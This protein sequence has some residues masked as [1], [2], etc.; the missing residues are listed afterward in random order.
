MPY[1]MLT[2]GE[3]VSATR[4][5]TGISTSYLMPYGMLTVGERVRATRVAH[6]AVGEKVWAAR[7]ATDISTGY[8]MPCGMLT[9]G[10]RVE[11]TRSAASHSIGSLLGAGYRHAA[12]QHGGSS[13]AV[14]KDEV[15][16]HAFDG[17][18]HF[19]EVACDGDL[20]DRI[21]QLSVV[22][23][24]ADGAP[25]IVAGDAVDAEADQLRDVQSLLDAPDE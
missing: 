17:L 4:F 16:A 8:P 1:G 24:Q 15:G 13:R 12:D 10:E 19:E 7:F 22:D 23:P 6:A 9:R 25:R 3:R 20:L 5:A 21:R 14:A 11:A 18:E 2:V